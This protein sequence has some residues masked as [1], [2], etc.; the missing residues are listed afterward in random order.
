MNE[1]DNPEPTTL[2]LM[3][4][5]AFNAPHLPDEITQRLNTAMKQHLQILVG[6]APGANHAFQDFLSAHNY[7]NVTVG[8]ARSIRYNAGNWET[9]QYGDNV[10][11]REKN[12]IAICDVA[13]II[14]VNRSSVIATNLERLKEQNKPTF[15]Y[16]VDQSTG[17]TQAGMIDP[18]RIYD[19][20]YQRYK[21]F[22]RRSTK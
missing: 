1:T 19:P 7:R 22:K 12:M 21:Y 15:L 18:K 14:W 9:Q 17:E 11:E 20:N 5:K 3:G 4:S 16:E 8:H 6:E 10:R 2:L 13:I